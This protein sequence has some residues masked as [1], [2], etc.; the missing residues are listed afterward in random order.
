MCRI[1]GLTNLNKTKNVNA[2][3]LKM[4]DLVSEANRDGFGYAISYKNSIYAEKFLNPSDF[5]GLGESALHEKMNLDIFQA[6][7]AAQYGRQEEKPLAI[8]AH[9]R[10]STNQKGY[11]EWSH[12]FV[13]QEMAFIHNGVVTV[14]DKNKN[15]YYDRMETTNDSEYLANLYWDKGLKGV[16]SVDG[17]FAFMNLNIGG[18]IEIVKDNTA[19]LFAAFLPELDSYIFATLESMIKRFADDLKLSCTKILPVTDMM[20]F[21]VKGSTLVSK[22]KFTRTVKKQRQ[23]TAL[24]KKAFQDQQGKKHGISIVKSKEQ[25]D[26][27]KEAYKVAFDND[28]YASKYQDADYWERMADPHNFEDSTTANVPSY[29]TLNDWED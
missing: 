8:I 17:Y 4:R 20:S 27:K 29:K 14:P 9:G 16:S 26:R 23:L 22:E 5:V 21:T 12:P 19:S 18:K 15:P 11:V 25:Y 2:I 6:D 7:F 1:M 3:A 10:T 24:E 13:R 28:A